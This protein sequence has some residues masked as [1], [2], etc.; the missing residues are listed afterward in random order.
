MTKPRT[1]KWDKSKDRGPTGKW[2]KK[3]SDSG[4]RRKRNPN[5]QKNEGAME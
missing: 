5:T 2:G 4:K 1:E 3:R